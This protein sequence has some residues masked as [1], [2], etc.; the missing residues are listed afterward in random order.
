[1]QIFQQP[2]LQGSVSRDAS[3]IILICWFDAQETFLIIIMVTL[4][5]K[6]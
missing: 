4:Y 3:E 1:M 2:L 6:V 5:S